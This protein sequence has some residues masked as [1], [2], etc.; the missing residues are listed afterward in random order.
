[1]STRTAAEPFKT[2]DGATRVTPSRFAA[3]VKVMSVGSSR[4]TS[5]EC[6]VWMVALMSPGDGPR[7]P[8]H[9]PRDPTDG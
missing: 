3:L 4:G 1:M 2:R 6:G 7:V 5:P 9:H 8:R